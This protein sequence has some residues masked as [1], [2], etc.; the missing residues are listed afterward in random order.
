MITQD[1]L[2]H[3]LHYDP[4]TGLFSWLNPT[5][6][7]VSKGQAAGVLNR[8]L[9][10]IYIGLFGKRHKAH[11]LAWLYVY[12]VWPSG[13]IDHINGDS[14]DNRIENLREVDKR[15]NG[16]NQRKA[17]KDSRTGLLGVTFDKRKQKY[18]ASI[19]YSGKRHFLGNYLTPEEAHQAYLEAKRQHHE[20]CTI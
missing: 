18:V 11:R 14:T 13:I 7:R 2:K 20:G 12:G 6:N 4:S 19:K 10:C 15:T 3:H 1:Q 16:Q 8:A 17:H 9:N 5:S